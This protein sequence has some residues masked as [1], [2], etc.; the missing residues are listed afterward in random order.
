MAKKNK[1]NKDDLDRVFL[2]ET[3]PHEMPL[4]FSTE[5]L[6]LKSRNY[7]QMDDIGKL[8]IEEIIL[9]PRKETIPYRYKINKSQDSYRRL[10]LIHPNSQFLIKNF[11]SEYSGLMLFYTSRSPATIRSPDKLASSFYSKTSWENIYKFKDNSVSINEMDQKA[12]HMPS[13]FSYRGYDRLWKFFNS[14]EY[15]DLEQRFP[16]LLTMDVARCFD[17]I[18]T[19]C[20]SWAT[21]SKSFTKENIEA[22]TFGNNFD[23]TLRHGNHS[24]TNGIPIGPE[25]S[26][27]FAEII[28]QKVDSEAIDRIDKNYQFDVH[29]SVRRYVDDIYIYAKSESVARYVQAAYTDCLLKYNLHPNAQKSEIS[30]RPF[31]TKKSSLVFQAFKA[32]EYLI[33]KIFFVDELKLTAKEIYEPEQLLKDYIGHIKSICHSNLSSYFDISSLLIAIFN[34][35]VKKLCAQ[36]KPDALENGERHFQVLK[37]ILDAC[38]FLYSVAPSVNASYKLSTTIILSVRFF[39]QNY[40]NKYDEFC[41][42]IYKCIS[43]FLKENRPLGLTVIEEHVDLEAINVVLAAKE[44]G[45]S[46]LLPSALVEHVFLSEGNPTYFSITSCLFYIENHDVYLQLKN[47]LIAEIDKKLEDISTVKTDSEVAFLFLDMIGC[48]FVP[49]HDR[50]KW[51]RKA[52]GNFGKQITK[53]EAEKFLLEPGIGWTDFWSSVDLLNVLEKKE[54]KNAY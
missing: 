14:H 27:I 23:Y 38:F 5:S 45:S 43:H 6:Y 48:P 11:Y 1:I 31:I 9:R 25:V 28:L 24:E 19:H 21:K 42:H 13:F 52:L 4:S 20:L 12:K 35:R 36:E 44:L 17:S 16:T 22:D 3:L 37:L 50:S 2:T 53:V 47:K 34:E 26:R 32:T 54:L 49:V 30:A 29:Y 7:A 40:E 41:T 10:A 46:L 15:V 51:L 33:Q 39:H 18:Y 8:I